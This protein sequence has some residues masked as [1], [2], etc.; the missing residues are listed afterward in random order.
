MKKH[1][2]HIVHEEC[3]DYKCESCGESFS[4]NSNLITHRKTVHK[5]QRKQNCEICGKSL[6]RISYLANQH[7]NCHLEAVREKIFEETHQNNSL[8]P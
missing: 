6:F 2:I 3:K 4:D 1:T 7:L 5:K 8:G